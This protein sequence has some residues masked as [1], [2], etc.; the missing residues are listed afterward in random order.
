MEVSERLDDPEWDAFLAA[1]PGGTYQQQTSLWARTKTFV[2][3][4][5]RR[6]VARREG[7]VVGGMQILVRRFPVFG[8]QV[9]TDGR[10]CNGKNWRAGASGLGLAKAATCCAAT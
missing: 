9:R 10:S 6:I 1:T 3:F 2:G 7:R 4:R 5:A 8:A